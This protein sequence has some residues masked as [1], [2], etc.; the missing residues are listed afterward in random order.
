M[1]GGR[2]GGLD[3]SDRQCVTHTL[4]DVT[5]RSIAGQRQVRAACLVNKLVLS[6]FVG[7]Y[8]APSG[9]TLGLDTLLREQLW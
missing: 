7:P 3:V 5:R 4:P 2:H 8:A 6:F 9:V 1:F